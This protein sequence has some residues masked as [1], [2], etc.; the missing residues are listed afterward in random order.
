[1]CSRISPTSATRAA[2][3]SIPPRP[4]TAN[5]PTSSA[6]PPAPAP[7]SCGCRS[8]SR[9]STTSSPISTR[10]CAARRAA[11]PDAALARSGLLGRLL[12]T[13]RRRP[14]AHAPTAGLSAYDFE[15]T[16]IDGE[17]LKLVDCRGRVLLV[18]N[19][20]SQCGF[21]EQYNGLQHLHHTYHER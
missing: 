17:P 2:W 11:M 16:T 18:V 3:S 1:S 4:R 12:G 20:A 19:T 10:R 21:T 9:R 14:G 6:L 15:F 13:L 7:T 8:A 5:S